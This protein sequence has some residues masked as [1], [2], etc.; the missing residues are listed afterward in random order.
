[1]KPTFHKR[2][3]TSTKH[4]WTMMKVTCF[5]WMIMFLQR[6]WIVILWRLLGTVFLLCVVVGHP[7]HQQRRLAVLQLEAQC[8]SGASG[9]IAMA[10]LIA[11][12]DCVLASI[13]LNVSHSFWRNPLQRSEHIVLQHINMEWNVADTQINPKPCPFT[14]SALACHFLMFAETWRPWH[15]N[16]KQT[17]RIWM[18]FVA[19]CWGRQLVATLI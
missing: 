1:M 8:D 18:S 16:F 17:L 11:W 9:L 3:K 13:G 19:F 4:Y 7:D 2:M 6:R 15:N 14:Q 10:F 5:E 12:E